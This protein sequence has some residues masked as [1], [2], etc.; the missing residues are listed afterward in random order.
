MNTITFR[1]IFVYLLTIY[2]NEGDS[3]VTREVA[4]RHFDLC[5]VCLV[6]WSHR[7]PL[8]RTYYPD[9]KQ[10]CGVQFSSWLK[11]GATYGDAAKF[12]Y[13]KIARENGLPTRQIDRWQSPMDRLHPNLRV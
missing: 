1:Q 6:L 12:V 13:E 2:M 3:T 8:P 9:M 10:L 5:D 11:R 7:E 4:D